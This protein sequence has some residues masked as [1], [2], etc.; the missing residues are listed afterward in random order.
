[1]SEKTLILKSGKCAWAKCFF[2]GYGRIPG[3]KPSFE[4]LKREFD[5]FFDSLFG[6]DTIKVFGSGSFLDEK[7]VPREA[8]MYFIE[9]CKDKG[10]TN[11]TIESR[12]EFIKEEILEEF[13]GI[14]LTVAIGLEIADDVILDKINK[15]FH[16]SDFENSAEIIHSCNGKV[17]TYLLV[18]LPFVE[19]LN[20]SLDKSVD[21]ALKFSDSIVLIN[22]LPHG[23]TPLFRMWLRGEWNF[24]SRVE[25]FQLTKKWR[26]H[27]KIELDPETF[28]FIPKFPE[29]I[30]ERLNG[31][32]EEFLTHPHFEVWQ[33]YLL[34]WYS[35]PRGK[36]I[37]LL[38]PCSYRKPYSESRTHRR[39]LME[40][41]K[42]KIYPRIH[43][44]M[45]SNAGLVPREFENYYPFNSYNWDESLETEEIKRRYIEVTEGRIRDYLGAHKD[46]YKKIFCFL[47]YDSEGY[48]S[49]NKACVDLNL[50][51]K[52]LLRKETYEKI[53]K[54]KRSL[55]KEA[56][57]NDLYEGLK[58]ENH[59]GD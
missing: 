2:C 9:R 41:K 44:V 54:E 17:R 23:N 22:L 46:N 30:R 36:D 11:L 5:S 20:E 34:R 58:N 43:Q 45:I 52:N 10:I 12:P 18:N 35:P 42:L 1:M 53:K 49:L 24:L 4:N 56:A 39:I 16:L 55:Q 7:Q 32:G 8:R 27:P 15:G 33:D 19:D 29:E 6:V 26:S 38:L 25:F 57:L 40:L 51:L 59:S 28:K 47:R 14:D 21:Y 50:N 37:L 13:K 3:K 31:V 48:K